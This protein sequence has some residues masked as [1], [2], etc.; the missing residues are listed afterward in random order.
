MVLQKIERRFGQSSLR[1]DG[2]EIVVCCPYCTR[3]GMTPD[4]SGHLGINLRK[5]V[6]HCYKCDWATRKATDW[7]S[8]VGVDLTS[9]VLQMA[10]RREVMD[11]LGKDV[12]ERKLPDFIWHPV[13]LPAG[14]SD[15]TPEHEFAQSLRDKNLADEDWYGDARYQLKAADGGK[16]AGYVL[17]PFLDDEGQVLYWQGR[18]ATPELLADKK[19]KKLNPDDREA[20]YGKKFFLYGMPSQ[21]ELDCLYLAEG[22]LDVLS[23]NAYFR[24]H[25][26]VGHLAVSLQGTSLSFPSAT[27]H[28]LNSQYGLIRWLR[29]KKIVIAFDPDAVKKADELRR[30]LRLFGHDTSV[31]RLR[32]HDP[33]EADDAELTAALNFSPYTIQLPD[34]K[35]R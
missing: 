28:P 17:F 25:G 9:E 19:R 34:L 4:T 35:P 1:K 6:A 2:D 29:P 16:W 15:L 5:N 10:S 20:P 23:L 27:R 30:V 8:K 3:R 18:A 11:R 12:V 24:R 26:M 33:N 32:K 7:L 31:M 22:T 21:P 14:A 13:Q